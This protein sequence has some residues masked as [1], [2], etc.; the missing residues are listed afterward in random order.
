MT[1]YSIPFPCKK[2]KSTTEYIQQLKIESQKYKKYIKNAVLAGDW[3]FD[4][5]VN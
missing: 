4:K 2:T 5:H 1:Q 3:E